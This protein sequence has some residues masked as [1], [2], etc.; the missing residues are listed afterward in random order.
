MTVLACVANTFCTSTSLA[1]ATVLVY[2]SAC[3]P[4]A[5]SIPAAV[6]KPAIIKDLLAL[7][8]L[9]SSCSGGGIFACFCFF[10]VYSFLFFIGIFLSVVGF[11]SV[12]K[13]NYVRILKISVT[14]KT[15]TIEIFP[16]LNYHI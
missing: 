14:A 16:L 3:A 13:D 1:T 9:C 10:F 11:L 4:V 8:D 2:W 5:P 12:L 7:C 6:V 15:V